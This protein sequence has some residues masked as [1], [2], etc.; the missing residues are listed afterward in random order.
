MKEAPINAGWIGHHAIDTPKA[1][2][3]RRSGRTDMRD[4]CIQKVDSTLERMKCASQAWCVESAP[5]CCPAQ[6]GR[7]GKLLRRG[8]WRTSPLSW[9]SADAGGAYTM[10]VRSGSVNVNPMST[11]SDFQGRK[12]PCFYAHRCHLM[13]YLRHCAPQERSTIVMHRNFL[14]A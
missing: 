6:I 12:P 8:C 9:H 7:N 5:C 2:T 3:A 11:S 1:I 10:T 13:R 14:D 4:S